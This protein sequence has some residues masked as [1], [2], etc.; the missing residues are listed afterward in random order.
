ML[1]LL[2][3]IVNVLLLTN[4]VSF[5]ILNLSASERS[6]KS[7]PTMYSETFAQLRSLSLMLADPERADRAM[8]DLL[9]SNIKLSRRVL[10][11]NLLRNLMH[12]GVGTNEVENY[13]EKMCK[14]NVRKG[15]NAR[16]VKE[17]MRS[18]VSDAEYDEHQI[19]KEFVSIEKAGRRN[20]VYCKDFLKT[21]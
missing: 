2:Q 13:V 5:S 21:F 16:L 19:R 18:K 6:N 14:N 9:C 17:C 15:R 20:T 12:L 11:R 3:T 1:L 4:S 8:H 10:T 7:N